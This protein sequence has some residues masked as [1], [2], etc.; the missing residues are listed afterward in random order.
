MAGPPVSL[1]IINYNG[2]R[3]LDPVLAA[4]GRSTLEFAEVLVVDDASTDGSVALLRERHPA[5]R[6]VALERNGGP[7]AVRNAGFRSA[8]HD[9]ILFIDNDV[10]LEPGCA[11]A[12]RAALAGEDVLVAQP[13]VLFADRPDTIQY[14]GADCHVLG[15]MM[16]RHHERQV[17]EVSAE[18][19]PT[20]S[21]VTCAFMVDRSRWR[22][23][24]PFDPTF[25]FNLEDHDFGTRSRI[26][27]H[28]LLS[29]PG[30]RCLHG[31]G[32]P[33]LS[34]RAGGVHTATR[35]YCLIRNRWRIVL[36]TYAARTIVLLAPSLAAYEVFQLVGA[37]RK[38]WLGPWVRAAGWMVA[39]P[40]TTLRRRREVQAT[41]RASDRELLREGPLPFTRGLLGGR[42]EGAARSWLERAAGA[43]WRAVRRFV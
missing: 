43:G 5:V 26:A 4:A 29:V 32:T 10:A 9:L 7:G 25:I 20:S 13:R 23:G 41:R 33:G 18:T 6:V 2:E 36:Q 40:G 27:G 21:M 17:A 39:N 35:V 34:Y 24:D 3:R 37:I 12:L 42:L 22:G 14:D 31:D 19:A 30:A 28:T 38:G 1:C 11:E 16:L 15:L 8:D